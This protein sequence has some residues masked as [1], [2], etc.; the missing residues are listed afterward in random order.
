MQGFQ[1]LLLVPDK[2][3]CGTRQHAEIILPG[4]IMVN[5]TE[6]FVCQNIERLAGFSKEKM[7]KVIRELLETY[8][9]RVKALETDQSLLIAIP[10]NLLMLT[11]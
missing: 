10:G 4:K 3:F 1:V 9:Q 5:S 7:Q 2:Y 6:S 8:N 11:G